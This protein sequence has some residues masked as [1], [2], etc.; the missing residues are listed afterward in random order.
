MLFCRVF[1]KRKIFECN[2]L[3]PQRNKRSKQ[4]GE[5]QQ[6][7]CKPQL[8]RSQELGLNNDEVYK[9]NDNTR[10]R[11]YRIA[12]SLT[13]YDAHFCGQYLIPRLSSSC[14]RREG[15]ALFFLNFSATYSAV[16]CASSSEE[17]PAEPLM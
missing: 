6:Y 17:N 3:Y 2:I 10:V 5:R 4:C 11:Y 14:T 13:L 7:A 8:F 9:A 15:N 1:I 12:Y 16:L